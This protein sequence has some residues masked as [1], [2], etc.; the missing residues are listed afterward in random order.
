MHV[1]IGFADKAV[2]AG[3]I[4]D[5]DLAA[6]FGLASGV[7][8]RVV[9]NEPDLRVATLAIEHVLKDWLKALDHEL[10]QSLAAIHMREVNVDFHNAS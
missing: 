10:L 9:A 6:V 2:F 8:L 7:V 1:A 3:G 4:A 5:V